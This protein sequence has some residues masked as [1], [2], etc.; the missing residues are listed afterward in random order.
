MNRMEA[1]GDLQGY[2]INDEWKIVKEPKQ[3]YITFYNGGWYNEETD[4]YVKSRA[5]S[6]HYWFLERTNDKGKLIK[7]WR[8]ERVKDCIRL[9]LAKIGRNYEWEQ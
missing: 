5:V 8:H 9:L 4:R 2:K 7:R 1:A 3:R 6:G